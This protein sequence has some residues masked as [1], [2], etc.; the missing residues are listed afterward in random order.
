MTG[1]VHVVTDCEQGKAPHDWHETI[2]T[3]TSTDPAL[4]VRTEL[5]VSCL[6]CGTRLTDFITALEAAL[7][8][9]EVK[10]E[11]VRN[12]DQSVRDWAVG[13]MKA[14]VACVDTRG[15][16]RMCGYHEGVDDAIERAF[17][18][19]VAALSGEPE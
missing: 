19:V 3:A 10:L 14:C 18:S 1:Y 6:S 8:T 16:W 4:P 11:A 9:C 7:A 13:S 12:A 17:E 15:S 2:M 5:W